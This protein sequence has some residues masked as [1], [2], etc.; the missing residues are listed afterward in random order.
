MRNGEG[1]EVEEVRG[2]KEEG[3]ARK[4]RGSEERKR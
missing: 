3:E 4:V 2:E 1:V